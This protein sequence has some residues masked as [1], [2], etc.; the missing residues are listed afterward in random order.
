MQ[1]QIAS[2]S[3]KPRSNGC[4]M[5]HATLLEHVSTG[6]A[7]FAKRKNIVQHVGQTHAT[8][9]VQ[10]CH[11]ILQT[12][13]IRLARALRSQST[14]LD[15]SLLIIIAEM[16]VALNF[17]NGA[18]VTFRLSSSLKYENYLVKSAH[19]KLRFVIH[20]PDLHRH[21]EFKAWDPA[22]QRTVLLNG[23]KEISV[24][25][26]SSCNEAHD[27]R[28]TSKPRESRNSGEQMVTLQ[29]SSNGHAISA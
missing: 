10:Q 7:G 1:R 21:V 19:Y 29:G 9:C 17:I 23:H 26:T 11:T 14:C 5:L 18:G 6:W 15:K 13:C 4:N 28:V 8:Y 27:V 2:S 16:C 12:C 24:T 22:G 25:P 20:H 3:L